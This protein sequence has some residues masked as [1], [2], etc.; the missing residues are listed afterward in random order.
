MNKRRCF[1]MFAVVAAMFMISAQAQAS[2]TPTYSISGAWTTAGNFDRVGSLYS[3]VNPGVTTPDD[4]FGN[5]PSYHYDTAKNAFQREYVVV[6]GSNGSVAFSGG[7]I[8]PIRGSRGV[9]LGYDSINNVYNLDSY[10]DRDV[11]GVSSIKVVHAVYSDDYNYNYTNHIGGYSS[12][13]SAS[14]AG[15]NSTI[16]DTDNLSALGLTLTSGKYVGDTSL[17]NL[18]T[19]LGANTTS[20]SK[21]NESTMFI[22][23]ATDDYAT[24]ISLG[25]LLALK[26]APNPTALARFNATSG[27]LRLVT[28]TD[29]DGGG[30]RSTKYVDSITGLNPVPIPASLFLFAPGLLGLFGLRKRIRN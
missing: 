8:N 21:E 3:V 5:D 27:Y 2:P 23:H 24:V 14:G 7:E 28:L 26:N 19:Y 6:T 17:L 22:F 20:L 25:E 16:H 11:T 13:F 9:T 12:T 18:L 29:L 10:D 4:E 30:A 15:M 1:V